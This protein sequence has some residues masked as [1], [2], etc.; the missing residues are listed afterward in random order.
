MKLVCVLAVHNEEAYLPYSL[1]PLGELGCLVV[2]VLDRCV[3]ASEK[4]VKRHLRN[5]ELVFKDSGC[6]KNSCAEAKSLG[7]DVAKKFGAD[8]I[9]MTD[10][11]VLLDVEAVQKAKCTLESSD[12]QVVVLPYGQYSLFG[13]FMSRVS[14]EAQNLFASLTRKLK[15]HPVRFGIYLGKAD[16]V[17]LE[18]KTSEFD[19][20]QKNVKTTWVPTKSLHLRPRLDVLSQMEH[21]VARTEMSQHNLMKALIFSISTFQPF[22]LAGYLKAKMKK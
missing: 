2:V 11:D 13:S 14:N 10:A 6:W 1:G 5:V 12:Y 19:Y 20:L 3:D 22:T 4:L 7:C 17:R 9:L 15:I 16:A 21:G 18:D 8:L